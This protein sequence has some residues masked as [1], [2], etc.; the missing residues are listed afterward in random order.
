MSYNDQQKQILQTELAL[1]AYVGMTAQQA[2]DAL[3]DPIIDK[4]RESMSRQEIY[5]NIESAALASLSV[6]QL[7]QIDLALSDTVDPFGNAEQ[8]FKNV[9]GAGSDTVSAL[10]AA[11]KVKVSKLIDLGLPEVEN[12]SLVGWVTELRGA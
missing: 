3:L 9:F 5:E 12:V 1:P 8:V 11:R 7:S 4:N 10:A 6:T 2:A